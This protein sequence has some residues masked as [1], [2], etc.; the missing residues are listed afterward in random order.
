MKRLICAGLL[1][2][3]ASALAQQQSIPPYNSPPTTTPPTFPSDQRPG[4]R[5]PPDTKAPAP[6]EPSNAEI[7]QQV[8]HK[9]ETEPLLED[10]QL[11]ATV[12]DAG[13]MLTGTVNNEQQH[14]LALRVAESY[15]GERQVIDK[16]KVRG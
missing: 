4:E 7:Q 6:S 9:L 3:A 1:L 10:M 15:A 2:F 16:I 13:I 5:M 12:T 11:K 14:K 8:Q